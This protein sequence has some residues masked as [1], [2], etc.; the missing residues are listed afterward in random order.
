MNAKEVITYLVEHEGIS[1]YRLAKRLG[2]QESLLSRACNG[3][4]DPGFNEVNR[5]LERLGFI[6]EIRE[7]DALDNAGSFAID[8]FGWAI[9]AMDKKDYDYLSVQRNLKQL[10][11]SRPGAHVLSEVSFKP[12]QIGDRYW[13]A[14]Y[15]ATIAYLATLTEADV[16]EFAEV[17]SNRAPKNW[18]PIRRMRKSQTDFDEIYASYNVQLPK[19]ELEWI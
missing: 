13:R 11:E 10:L 2:A 12:K 5:W 19:G 8:R 9:D 17:K 6:L 4:S 16:P 7:A 1:R 15:A 3:V 18:S 14:F